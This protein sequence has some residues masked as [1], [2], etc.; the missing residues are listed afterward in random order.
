M[1]GDKHHPSSW[2]ENKQS[3]S[4]AWPVSGQESGSALRSLRHVPDKANTI[5]SASKLSR[6]IVIMMIFSVVLVILV[7][8]W[9]RRLKLQGVLSSQSCDSIEYTSFRRHFIFHVLISHLGCG[10]VCRRT[11]ILFCFFIFK[12][13]YIVRLCKK[14]HGINQNANKRVADLKGRKTRC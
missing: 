1:L 12:T 3:R 14:T 4:V 5:F 9:H 8:F 10:S 7:C 6:L 13:V 11:P 2:L